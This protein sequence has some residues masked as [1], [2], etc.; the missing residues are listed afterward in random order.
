[1]PTCRARS[2]RSG[3]D[4]AGCRSGSQRD[5]HGRGRGDRRGD[6]E[7]RRGVQPVHGPVVPAADVGSAAALH[8]AV[9][10]WRQRAHDLPL[11]RLLPPDDATA[12]RLAVRAERR[13]PTRRDPGDTIADLVQRVG[14]L[15]RRHPRPSERH[16]QLL[17]GGRSR[18]QPADPHRHPRRHRLHRR[19]TELGFVPARQ[20]RDLRALP[21][22]TVPVS[23]SVAA[24]AWWSASSTTSPASPYNAARSN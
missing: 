18:L 16:R 2:R 12:G 8:L 9:Q 3:D 10:R 15:Q 23:R 11:V 13:D 1:M 7:G 5:D 20:Q 6:R 14:E 17:V 24:R 19:R 22:R 4:P 21:A